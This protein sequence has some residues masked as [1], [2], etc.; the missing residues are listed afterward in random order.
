MEPIIPAAGE[1]RTAREHRISDVLSRR[2]AFGLGV[3]AMGITGPIKYIGE[4]ALAADLKNLKRALQ[5][6]SPVDV[7][8]PSV[9]PS[10]A[11]PAS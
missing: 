10:K 1:R 7:F 3:A 5:T 4:A 9:S 2:R 11:A 8:M 6:T